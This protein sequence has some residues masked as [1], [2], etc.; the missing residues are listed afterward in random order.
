M[1]NNKIVDINTYKL[2]KQ[3]NKTVK[4]KMFLEEYEDRLNEIF[5]PTGDNFWDYI[6]KDSKE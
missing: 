1:K 4:E 3:L 2:Q 5:I 6:N